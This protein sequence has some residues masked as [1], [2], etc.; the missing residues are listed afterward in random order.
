MLNGVMGYHFCLCNDVEC[1]MFFSLYAIIE[2]ERGEIK[3][4]TISFSNT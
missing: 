1:L 2:D 3:L 4:W